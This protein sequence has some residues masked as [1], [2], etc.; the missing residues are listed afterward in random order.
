MALTKEEI[1]EAVAE[2][3]GFPKNQSGELIEIIKKTLVSG[4]D[5][6]VSRFGKFRVREKK[7]R[8][9][10]NP[11]TGEDMTLESRR[12]VTFKCS[13]RLRDKINKSQ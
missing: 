10:R 3:T 13:G 9:G 12:V 1:I 5:V 2:D 11:A 6:L 7:T 4:D 8:K